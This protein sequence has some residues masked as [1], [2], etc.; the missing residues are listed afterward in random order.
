MGAYLYFKTTSNPDQV[1]N[2]LETNEVQQKLSSLDEQGIFIVNLDHLEWIKENRPDLLK[3][4]ES[5]LSTGD[6]KT[7]GGISSKADEAGYDEEDLL[8]MWTQIFEE[9]N[10]RFEMKYYAHS[11]AFSEEE[12]YFSLE[13]MKRITNNGALLSGKSS[14]SEHVVELY[15]S[16][17]C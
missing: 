11:C 13:Q 2:Y 4:E 17:T 8:E 7:S 16:A 15:N 10:K 9:L 1:N 6:I 12:C 3:W 14:K 5:K